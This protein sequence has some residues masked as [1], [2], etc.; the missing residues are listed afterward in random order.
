LTFGYDALS[1]NT[2]QG[3]P[4]GTVGYQYDA[5]GRRTRMTWP[6]S[7]YVSYDHLVTGE[8]TVT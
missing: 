5:A 8:V 2:S 1:R 3:G 4:R 6:N 7:F